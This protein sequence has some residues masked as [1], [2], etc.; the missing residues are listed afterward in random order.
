MTGLQFQL[1]RPGTQ[2]RTRRAPANIK[3]LMQDAARLDGLLT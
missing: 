2:S 3:L 1:L